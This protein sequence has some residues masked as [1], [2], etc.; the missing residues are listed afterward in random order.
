MAVNVVLAREIKV[1]DVIRVGGQ[2][3]SV[4]GVLL[5][6]PNY[7]DVDLHNETGPYGLHLH[8]SQPVDLVV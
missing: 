6:Q 4:V 8:A 7:V 3:W 2:D 1:G 5:E